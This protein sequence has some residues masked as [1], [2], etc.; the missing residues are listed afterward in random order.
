MKYVATGAALMRSNLTIVINDEAADDHRLSVDVEI[1]GL[2]L[3]GFV[4]SVENY[5]KK[6]D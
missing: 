6:Y 4:H 1:A 3:P 5:L 2:S